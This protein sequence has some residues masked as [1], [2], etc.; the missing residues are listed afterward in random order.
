VRLLCGHTG[1]FHSSGAIPIAREIALRAGCRMGLL[2]PRVRTVGWAR[3]ADHH[4]VPSRVG[5]K[6]TRSAKFRSIRIAA[7][8]VMDEPSRLLVLMFW[9]FYL[10]L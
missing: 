5:Y 8:L 9:D 6:C 3:L 1:A 7:S 10:P 4:W 2:L